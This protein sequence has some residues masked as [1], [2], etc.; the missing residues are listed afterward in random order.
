[1]RKCEEMLTFY[2]MSWWMLTFSENSS[3]Y[4]LMVQYALSARCPTVCRLRTQ[5]GH[6]GEGKKANPGDSQV[7]GCFGIKEGER[8]SKRY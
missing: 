8:E 7:F 4:V 6:S 2:S 1:M 3:L 5:R